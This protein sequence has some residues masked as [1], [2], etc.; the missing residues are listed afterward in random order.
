MTAD[1]TTI[2]D[3]ALS[4]HL[5]KKRMQFPEISGHVAFIFLIRITDKTR[6]VTVSI[7][8]HYPKQLI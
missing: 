1:A 3:A 5:K 6:K 2:S 8:N 4:A 7:I